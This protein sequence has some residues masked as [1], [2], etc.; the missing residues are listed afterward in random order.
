MVSCQNNTFALDMGFLRDPEG[1][2]PGVSAFAKKDGGAIVRT[3]K[4]TFG[5]GDNF[6]SAWHLFD[7]LPQGVAGWEPKHAYP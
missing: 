5:P 1:Y 4:S 6:C 7:L 3:G 2:W